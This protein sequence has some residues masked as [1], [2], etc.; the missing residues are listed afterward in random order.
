MAS[1]RAIE[2]AGQHIG[3]QPGQ[4]GANVEAL[5]QALRFQ[6][7]T[8]ALLQGLGVQQGRDATETFLHLLDR[9]S[10]MQP[11]IAAEYAQ[12]YFH[13]DPAALTEYMA[14][15]GRLHEEYARFLREEKA[16]GF[17]PKKA[18]D[19]A[20]R[21][22]NALRDLSNQ[23]ERLWAQLIPVLIPYLKSFNEWLAR[24]LQT[25]QASPQ[26]HDALEKL[27]AALDDFFAVLSK[28]QELLTTGALATFKVVIAGL[29]LLLDRLDRLGKMLEWVNDQLHTPGSIF[30]KASP[31]TK[32]GEKARVA[33]V[34]VADQAW[35]AALDAVVPGLGTLADMGYGSKSWQHLKDKLSAGFASLRSFIEHDEGFS[36]T[37]YPDA[38]GMA[39]GYG[40]RIAPGEEALLHRSISRADRSAL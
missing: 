38:G 9:F 15:L 29:D 36:P 35:K 23:M 13:I 4:A 24:T 33:G 11:Y 16:S 25:L 39:I 32:P 3:L 30:E 28:H 1:L 40:H 37:A 17:D 19:D 26:A 12:R 21:Y 20:M 18:A 34:E 6:P 27:T 22:Q 10:H 2:S 8:R 5:G 31:A 14:N 7:G